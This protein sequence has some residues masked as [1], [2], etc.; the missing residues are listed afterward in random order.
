MTLTLKKGEPGREVRAGVGLGTRVL[1]V[2]EAGWGDGVCV[3]GAPRRCTQPGVA[4]GGGGIDR[5]VYP[6]IY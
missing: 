1:A 3:A 2:T 6:R 4:G 5:A